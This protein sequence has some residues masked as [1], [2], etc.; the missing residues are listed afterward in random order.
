MLVSATL[1]TG[2]PITGAAVAR[3]VKP[4]PVRVTVVAVV[5][6]EPEFV[7]LIAVT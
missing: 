6:P 1:A 7:T 5:Q 3:V 2:L 4:P